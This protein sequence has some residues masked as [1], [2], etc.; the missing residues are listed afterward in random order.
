MSRGFRRGTSHIFKQMNIS[1][2]KAIRGIWAMSIRH[3][4]THARSHRSFRESHRT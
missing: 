4:H 3:H 1:S 2:K